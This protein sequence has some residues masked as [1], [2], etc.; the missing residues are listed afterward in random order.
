MTFRPF[1]S[2]SYAEH[3]R[4]G[5]WRDVLGQLGLQG[6][7]APTFYSSHATASRRE[8]K[9]MTLVKLAAGSQGIGPLSG[10]HDDTLPTVLLTIEDGA[11]LRAGGHQIIPAG[12]LLV[13]PRD[14]DWTLQ[15][16]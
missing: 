16:Q 6:L 3:D 10:S 13:L 9:G 15:F 4:P 2:E 11:V 8:A 1:T 12:H 7:A 14:G 5:A